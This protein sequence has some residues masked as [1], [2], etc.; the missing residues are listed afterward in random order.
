MLVHA[1]FS[2]IGRK[3]YELLIDMG[4]ERARTFAAMIRQHPDFELTTEPEL[5]ILTYRYCPRNV[6]QALVAATAQQRAAVNDLLDQVCM[7]L[8]KHQREAG[9]T[10]VSRTRLR[11]GCH[12]EE[13]TVLRVVLANPLTTDEILAAVLA[14]QCEIVQQPEIQGLLRQVEELCASLEAQDN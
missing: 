5:N 14:E 10:F 2:I 7:L 3:G 1:G 13:L 9:K 8:Q 6:Q 12:D 11:V 4:I